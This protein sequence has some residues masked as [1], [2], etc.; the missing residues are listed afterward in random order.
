MVT[1]RSRCV[2]NVAT[3]RFVIGQNRLD[4]LL[5]VPLVKWTD[6]LPPTSPAHNDVPYAFKAWALYEASKQYTTLLW[7]DAC[8]VPRDLTP[9]FERIEREGYWMS[10]NGWTNAE[11]TAESAYED[12][13]ITREENARIPH[14]V[15][16]A[17]GISLKHA[18]GAGFL[19]GYLRLA[20]ANAFRGP[21]WNS[22]HPEHGNNPGAVPCG[23]ETVRGHRHDQ[24]CASVI[25]WKLG[26][27]LTEPPNWFSYKGAETVDTVLIADGDYA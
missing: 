3:G 10:R 26:F 23:D 6:H 8:I 22:N 17:F 24:S 12:L 27:E 18:K 15:A 9:L 5:T 4:S 16:T 19:G 11:W 20:Q 1:F 25:A 7:A 13:G 2:V 14:V 21:W